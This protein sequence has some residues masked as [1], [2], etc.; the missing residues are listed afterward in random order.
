MRVSEVVTRRDV[1]EHFIVIIVPNGVPVL[2]Y[3]LRFLYYI[4]DLVGLALF[5]TKGKRGKILVYLLFNVTTGIKSPKIL[6]LEDTTRL[7]AISEDP[8]RVF[9]NFVELRSET[10]GVTVCTVPQLSSCPSWG[11]TSLFNGPTPF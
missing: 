8:T 3:R 7:R 5:I 11:S 10:T 1:S 4:T 9:E 6:N 2:L